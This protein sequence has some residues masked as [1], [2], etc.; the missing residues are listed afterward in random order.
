MS[1][2]RG[3]VSS[4]FGIVLRDRWIG[5]QGK[6]GNGVKRGVMARTLVALLV[7]H[8]AWRKL[9]VL[10]VER[11][12]L[13]VP[14][15]GRH[16]RPGDLGPRQLLQRRLRRREAM[17]A[18]LSVCVCVCARTRDHRRWRLLLSIGRVLDRRPPVRVRIPIAGVPL[19][20]QVRIV[21]APDARL[22]LAK[23]HLGLERHPAGEPDAHV[24]EPPRRRL[25]LLAGLPAADVVAHHVGHGGGVE[26]RREHRAPVVLDPRGGQLAPEHAP[27][28]ELDVRAV[29]DEAVLVQQAGEVAGRRLPGRRRGPRD[30]RRADDVLRTPSSRYRRRW[31]RDAQRCPCRR[32]RGR[33]RL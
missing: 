30:A 23:R 4:L 8:P 21:V 3:N 1:A 29:W 31:R 18:P 27:V 10:H 14:H 9:P 5:A 25:L 16:I 28:E 15:L 19:P 11:L 6:G 17:F 2:V 20:V 13:R 22:R 12:L 26:G 24:G 7:H 33:G 32:R